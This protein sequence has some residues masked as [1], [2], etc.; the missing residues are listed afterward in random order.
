[1]HRTERLLGLVQMLRRHRRPVTGEAMAREFS[2]S[3]RTIY[4]DVLH[5]QGSG[6]PIRGE[7][8]IGYVLD[9][10][11]DLPPLMFSPDE[12]E[13]LMLGARFVQERGDP[14]LVRAA[15]DAVAKIHAVLPAALKPVFADASVFAPAWR[16]APPDGVD[17][18]VVRRAL[19][20]GRKLGI[21]Y[22]DEQGR[23]TVRTIWPIA[24][25]YWSATRIVVA[26]C[27]LRAGFRHFRADRIE[28]LEERDERYPT[29]RATL[30]ARWREAIAAEMPQRGEKT[31]GAEASS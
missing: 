19:R 10:G 12:L 30:L 16:D 17:L 4:R 26:W 11:F 8:G 18:G 6:V 25:G 31:S 28:R 21:H 23:A 13:A 29:G 14:G 27:E 22:R 24:V 7:A 9:P 15:D 5:L 1:M 3:V 20:A 2:V